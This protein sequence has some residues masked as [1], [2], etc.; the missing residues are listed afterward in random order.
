M[1][2]KKLKSLVN[3]K[4][5]A[6]SNK[7]E[8]G[9]KKATFIS[10]WT[11]G[12]KYDSRLKN[13]LTCRIKNQVFLI[14]E[15]ENEMDK[16]A[17]HI[18]TAK[19]KSLGYVGRNEAAQLSQLLDSKMIDNVGYIVALQSDLN[20]EIY[21]VKISIPVSEEVLDKSKIAKLKEIDFVF[22]KSTNNNLY[23]LLS[24][25]EN[26]LREVKILLEKAGIS[27]ERIGISYAPSSSGKLFRWYLRIDNN[28]DKA[29]I[30]KQLRDNFPVLKERYDNQF[31]E[32][33]LELQDEELQGLKV[34]RDVFK[35]KSIELK[36]SLQTFL[37]REA[38]YNDQFEKMTKIFLPEINFI[39]DSIDV[40][41][42]EVEDYTVAL[43]KISEINSDPLYRGTKINTLD[44]WFEIHFNTGQKDDGRIYFKR[45]GST[46]D[47][48]VSFK[49]SQK[50]DINYLRN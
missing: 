44:K 45:E 42:Q 5:T 28:S 30:E 6:H 27:I 34:Q 26:V 13:L 8:I 21:G 14:R 4:K 39:R 41:K 23:I 9:K 19:K 36:K 43:T 3:R 24:C 17:I 2:F 7:Y 37:K 32:A 29:L 12:I 22:E 25:E 38:F 33:Y 50:K 10:F 35:N 47:I 15:P 1:F 11:A 48:L 46:L 18:V 49:A 16:N 40:L 31:N 20:D